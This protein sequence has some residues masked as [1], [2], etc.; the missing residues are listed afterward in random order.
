MESRK[1]IVALGL[2][3]EGTNYLG[4]Q[5]QK[6]SKMTIQGLLEAGLKKGC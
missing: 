6:S 4:F 3:Y 5:K 2:E 1:Y